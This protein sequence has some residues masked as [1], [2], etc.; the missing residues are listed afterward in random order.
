MKFRFLASLLIASNLI[1]QTVPSLSDL[2]PSIP[3]FNQTSYW[4]ISGGFAAI[5]PKL[6]IGFRFQKE[7]W[8]GDASLTEATLP[9]NVFSQSLQYTHLYYPKPNLSSESYL[10]LSTALHYTFGK[11]PVGQ[12]SNLSLGAVTGYQFRIRNHF[13]FIEG[14]LGFPLI[15]LDG[16]RL[17]LNTHF[18]PIPSLSYG[19]SF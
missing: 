12:S 2:D 11:Y 19:I 5:I 13:H 15:W 8:G 3:L 10:G 16:H 4:Y 1:A 9:P 7:R 14:K 17:H 6:S 18:I